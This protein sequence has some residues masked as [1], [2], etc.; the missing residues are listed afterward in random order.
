MPI[1]SVRVSGKAKEELI[2]L[3]RKTK[4]ENWN[5]LC[6]WAL[7]RSLSVTIGQ[8]LPHVN[9]V[10]DSNVEMTWR[11]FTGKHEELYWAIVRERC[12]R[13]GL[14]ALD[15]GVV[16]GQFKLHLHRGIQYLAAMK[17]IDIAKLVS[18]SIE[19]MDDEN[20]VSIPA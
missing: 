2:R 17:E 5:T 6:R 19:S 18:L 20:A 13:D 8:P 12:R 3:K 1:D 11:T 15:E 10:T 4:I 9:H 7:C 16:A 14:D